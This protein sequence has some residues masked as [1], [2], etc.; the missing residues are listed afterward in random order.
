MMDETFRFILW[1]F[2]CNNFFSVAQTCSM[3]FRS[4]E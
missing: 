4:G 3:G 1:S 2:F